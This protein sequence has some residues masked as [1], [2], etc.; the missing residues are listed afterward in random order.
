MAIEVHGPSKGSQTVFSVGPGEL[1]SW[2][3]V[4]PPHVETASARAADE[5]EL[6]RLHGADLAA[7]CHSDYQLGYEIYRALTEVITARLNAM[8]L[9]LYDIIAVA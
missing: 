6:L 1:F 4:V 2:S 9:Q 7:L 3:A 5:T 8:R